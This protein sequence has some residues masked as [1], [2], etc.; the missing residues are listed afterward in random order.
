M[1]ENIVIAGVTVKRDD[2]GLYC[3]ND[4]WRA[5]GSNKSEKVGNWSKTSATKKLIEQQGLNATKLAFTQSAGR[6]GGTFANK[7]LVYDYAMWISPEFKSHVISVFDAHVTGNVEQSLSAAVE[8]LKL[9]M[10]D[11]SKAVN[12]ASV[13]FDDIKDCGKSWGKAGADIRKAKKAAVDQLEMLKDE[14]QGKLEF[15]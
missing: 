1:N 6:H 14:I 5:R 13:H 8:S 12:C 4:L 10:I 2:N 15:K 3:L 7:A 9:N 11:I